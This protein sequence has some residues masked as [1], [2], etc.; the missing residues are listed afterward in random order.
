YY[1]L[2]RRNGDQ[3]SHVKTLYRFTVQPREPHEFDEMCHFHSTSP[4]SHFTQRL[5]CSGPT[6]QGRVTLSDMKLIVTEDHQRHE[7]TLHSEEERRAALWR[8]FAIDVGR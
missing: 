8:H 2:E 5:V 6:E 4:Q 7:T 3:R 1:L